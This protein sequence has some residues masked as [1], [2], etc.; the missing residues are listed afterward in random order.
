MTSWLPRPWQALVVVIAA[1]GV[2]FLV[3]WFAVDAIAQARIA[4]W[5]TRPEVENWA[6]PYAGLHG[7]PEALALGVAILALGVL[8]ALVALRRHRAGA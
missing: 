3:R 1:A 8:A 4:E 5:A 2:F 7:I 6:D